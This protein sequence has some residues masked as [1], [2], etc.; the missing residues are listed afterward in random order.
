[1]GTFE[2]QL[3][4]EEVLL[5]S[6][7][8]PKFK[9]IFAYREFEKRRRNS[10]FSAE[11]WKTRCFAGFVGLTHVG[12]KK[13]N[14]AVAFP[15]KEGNQRKRNSSTCEVQNQEHDFLKK[16]GWI[17]EGE[18]PNSTWKTDRES[19]SSKKRRTHQ[20]YRTRNAEHPFLLFVSSSCLQKQWKGPR[21]RT[22]SSSRTVE[23][24]GD[25]R[26]IVVREIE[27]FLGLYR[28][29]DIRKSRQLAHFYLVF[30]FRFLTFVSFSFLSI[31][32]RKGR[33]I[34]PSKLSLLL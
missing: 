29:P 4:K 6:S 12:D 18:R 15:V 19:P 7:Y 8:V 14:R 21:W 5:C 23:K 1:M 28:S 26:E 30:S 9:Q 10:I 31:G 27:E 20:K 11:Q 24:E 32:S 2:I 22:P 33:G 17:C 25:A 13:R 3:R 34:P 16:K